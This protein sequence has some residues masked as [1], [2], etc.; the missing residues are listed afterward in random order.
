MRDS[1]TPCNVGIAFSDCSEFEVHLCKLCT[2][3]IYELRQ[4]QTNDFQY[5][6]RF[7]FLLLSFR[8]VTCFVNIRGIK[9]LVMEIQHIYCGDVYHTVRELLIT[10]VRQGK[11]K[12]I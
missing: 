8:Q 2:N 4:M 6:Y 12:F 7:W 9:I 11:F 10:G 5:I 1:T 3:I